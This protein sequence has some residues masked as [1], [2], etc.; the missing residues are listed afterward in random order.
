MTTIKSK[1][2]MKAKMNEKD[3][4]NDSK[5]AETLLA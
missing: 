1:L 3:F 5:E 2:E 4:N